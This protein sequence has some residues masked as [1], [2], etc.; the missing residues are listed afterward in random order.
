MKPGR[1]R[2]SLG[3][4]VPGGSF[5]AEKSNAGGNRVRVR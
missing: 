3:L 2:M 4:A 5:L 1:W